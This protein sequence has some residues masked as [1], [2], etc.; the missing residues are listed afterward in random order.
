MK[1][2]WRVG[3]CI[4]Y[5]QHPD[6]GK[7]CY[8]PRSYLWYSTVRVTLQKSDGR[9]V[10]FTTRNA[11]TNVHAIAPEA[12]DA[13]GQEGGSL[14]PTTKAAAAD[15]LVQ[16]LATQNRVW[17]YQ[18]LDRSFGMPVSVQCVREDDVGKAESMALI[19]YNIM[20][21]LRLLGYDVHA[22]TFDNHPTNVVRTVH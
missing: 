7:A 14:A 1:S 12:G 19:T 20:S 13:P 3:S 9:L 15:K 22:I 21:E 6:S 18:S 5:V 4:G 2:R 16:S 10:G 11:F 8:Q 17:Y